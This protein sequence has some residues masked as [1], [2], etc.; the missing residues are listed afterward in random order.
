M[1]PVRPFIARVKLRNYKSI[2]RCDLA[3]GPL[4]YLVGQNGAGKSNF[5]DALHFVADALSGSL[6]NALDVRGGLSEVRRRSGGHPTHFGIRVEV[7]LG[8]NRNGYYAF[9]IGA[10]QAGGF[11]VQ[12]E[13]CG[14][15]EAA[16]GPRFT[17][18]RGQV[19]RHSET[20]F[21][22][23][24]ADRL[25]LV[26]AAGIPAFR[27][28][29]DALTAMGFY[30]LNPK[31][32]REL[33]KPQDGSLLKPAG[34]NMASVIGYLARHAPDRKRLVEE[35]LT[36]VVPSV[37]GVQRIAVGPMESLE[38][39]QDASGAQHPWRFLA[40]SMSDGTLRAL[41][42]L[43]ALFQGSVEREPTLVGIEEPELAL[44]PAAASVLRE[45][46]S[47]ASERTQ[48]LLTSHS[49]E[50][51]NAPEIE[52]SQLVAVEFR[53]GTTV[54]GPVDQASRTMLQEQLYTAGELLSLN[55]LSPDEAV[56]A[57]NE[58]R[59]LVLFGSATQ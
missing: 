42:V 2:A 19:I 16:E 31:V 12:K 45:A 13:E 8:D 21:P 37:H 55:Q 14:I 24:T 51:L 49:P 57:R 32:I 7:R 58:N 56:L 17:V 4:T 36:Q 47:R 46:I 22:A 11:V 6:D 59:Q 29:F 40:N 33:Q 54:L 25:A 30:N 35:Y 3:L 34:E 48:V 15:G 18:E 5:V 53:D 38:F 10:Q 27:P 28:V 1:N 20:V 41:G 50:L 52:D 43:T 39:R 9:E 23:V 44:H 26:A